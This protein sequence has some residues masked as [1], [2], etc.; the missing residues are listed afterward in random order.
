[1]AIADHYSG[2][3]DPA[4][5]QLRDRHGLLARVAQL[6]KHPQLLGFSDRHLPGSSSHSPLSHLWVA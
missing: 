2:K 6:L 5:A 4:G 3:V 1:V